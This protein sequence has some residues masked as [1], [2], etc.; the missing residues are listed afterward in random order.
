MIYR[1]LRRDV[2]MQIER[3]ILHCEMAAFTTD[4]WTARNGDPFVSLTLHYVTKD[5]ELKNLSLDSQNFIWRHTGILLAQGIDHMSSQ[6]PGLQREDLYKVGVTD[7]AA[8]MKKAITESKEISDHLTC[9]DHLLNTCLT[10][11][12]EKSEGI[13]GIIKKC[14]RLA[15]KTHQSSLDWQGIKKACLEANIEPVKVIQPIVTR[16]NS[17]FMMLKSILRLKAS[18]L[19]ALETQTNQIFKV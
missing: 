14:K 6:F 9:A 5:F 2:K 8:N 1:N 16:W 11:A 17:N 10:K 12:V 3:G 18:L 15:Q 4:G 13:N 7:A 19:V